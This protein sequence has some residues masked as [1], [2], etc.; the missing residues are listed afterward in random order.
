MAAAIGIIT[1]TGIGTTDTTP[2]A[3]GI[4]VTITGGGTI[5]RG[6]TSVSASV[7]LGA[8]GIATTITDAGTSR[9]RA[10]HHL[11][12]L[13]RGVVCHARGTMRDGRRGRQGTSE[14]SCRARTRVA[15]LISMLHLP[16]SSI[17]ALLSSTTV[18]S[19]A[20]G[21]TG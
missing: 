8:M 11:A 7:P 15:S 9:G 19:R 17:A 5:R 2:T 6:R 3:I 14:N 16:G 18:V 21:V 13:T 1:A 10:W 12:H 20:P 4:T